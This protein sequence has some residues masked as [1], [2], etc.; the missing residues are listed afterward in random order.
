[1]PFP[2]TCL[3]RMF[4]HRTR[5]LYQNPG[6]ARIFAIR[7]AGPRSASRSGVRIASSSLVFRSKKEGHPS[8]VLLFWCPDGLFTCSGRVNRPCAKV[9]ASGRKHLG[10]RTRAAA[11]RGRFAPSLDALPAVMLFSF[12][13]SWRTLLMLGANE[14]PLRQGFRLRAK[15]LGTAHSRRGPVRPS[16]FPLQGRSDRGNL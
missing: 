9:F 7:G 4:L 6:V 12:L 14:S 3:L 15:T 2:I 13:V 8:D 5:C 1:M 16:P 11:P 10:R